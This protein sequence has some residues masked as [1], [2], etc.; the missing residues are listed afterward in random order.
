METAP[1]VAPETEQAFVI[2]SREGFGD[3]G[4]DVLLREAEIEPIEV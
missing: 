2:A 4:L 3:K 1:L